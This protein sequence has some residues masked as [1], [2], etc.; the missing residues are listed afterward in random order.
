MRRWVHWLCLEEG[1]GRPG[2][3]M[4]WHPGVSATRR[5]RP[6]TPRES[7]KFAGWSRPSRFV[8]RT[9]AVAKKG[10]AP[11]TTAVATLSRA[12]KREQATKLRP[13][14]SRPS[15]PAA[16]A[17]EAAKR[18]ALTNRYRRG[19]LHDLTLL[20]SRAGAQDA[21]CR[22]TSPRTPSCASTMR[23]CAMRCVATRT[24]D[25]PRALTLSA[26]PPCPPNAVAAL[27]FRQRQQR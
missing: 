26:L 10:E 9:T 24:R 27:H 21:G 13:T 22:T 19:S 11:R 20:R 25:A 5:D 1:L 8:A 15:N 14:K 7:G 23:C 3:P 16:G 12:Q 17:L 4:N 6:T 2:K 18:S